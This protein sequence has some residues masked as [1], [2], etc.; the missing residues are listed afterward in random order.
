MGL[1]FFFFLFMI[2]FM[3]GLCIEIKSLRFSMQI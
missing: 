3:L 1:I 2:Y